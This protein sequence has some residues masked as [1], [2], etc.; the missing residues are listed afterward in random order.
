[1]LQGVQLLVEIAK[2]PQADGVISRASCENAFE[3]RVEGD[4]VQ[5]VC[6]CLFLAVKGGLVH[7]HARVGNLPCAVV[8]DATDEEAVNRMVLNI[9]DYG[10]VR[11][12]GSGR[13]NLRIALGEAALQIPSSD[14]HVFAAGDQAAFVQGTPRET[15]TL[16]VVSLEL[17]LEFDA[18]IAF[19]G[20]GVLG[21]VEDQN[22]AV[23]AQGGDDLGI[24]GLVAGLVDLTGVVDLLHDLELEG[25]FRIAVA[26][27]LAGL[28]VKRLEIRGGEIGHVDVGNLEVVLGLAR[29][30]GAQ[31]DAVG[32]Q[33]GALDGPLVGK[34]LG[35]QCR[36]LQ[37]ATVEHVVE[38]DTVL[39][40]HLVLLVDL[41]LPLDLLVVKALDGRVCSIISA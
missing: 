5:G 33:V 11:R 12:V 6:V 16:L 24:L 27:D 19:G 15:E 9:V 20:V 1:M 38:K 41:L 17:S 36:P 28:F 34:P 37:G 39:L 4:A 29:G 25:L 14:S 3:L 7:G 13:S 22:L 8:R 21:A 10:G 23:D 40:P 18:A 31:D 2:I 30:V 26:A 35:C 32:A